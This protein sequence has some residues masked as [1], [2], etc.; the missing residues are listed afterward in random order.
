MQSSSI[1]QLNPELAASARQ[2]LTDFL[3]PPQQ[4]LTDAEREL[5][6]SGTSISVPFG[7]IDIQAFSWGKGT[8]AVL[9][10]H[11]W[12][13]YGLQWRNFIEPLVRS[14]YRVVTFDAP[15][16]GSTAGVQTNGFEMAEAISMVARHQGS[17]AAT[18]AHSLGAASTT[19]AL[20]AGMQTGKVVYLGAVCW[21]ANAAKLFAKRARLSEEVESAFIDLAQVQFGRDLWERFS[22]E[23]TAKNLTIPALLFHDSRDREVAIGESQAIAKIWSGAQLVATSGLGHRRILN[24]ESVIRSTIEFL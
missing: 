16:H 15:A 6:A 13:G 17:F 22:I 7:A 4:P 24:D 9:L 5:L 1:R 10:V 20:S 11:G 2:A 12:G 8:E 23:T 3:T 19:L 14:G 18:I 21:L